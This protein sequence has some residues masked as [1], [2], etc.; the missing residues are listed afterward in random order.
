[1]TLKPARTE[2]YL[3]WTYPRYQPAEEGGLISFVQMS[4]MPFS[5][6]A[7]DPSGYSMIGVQRHPVYDYD[8]PD[9][10]PRPSARI[11][12]DIMNEQ[13]RIIIKGE[14]TTNF[15]HPDSVNQ[16][17]SGTPAYAGPSGLFTHDRDF[18]GDLVGIFLS[19]ISGGSQYVMVQGDIW[20][21]TEIVHNPDGTYVHM[22]L[23][24]PRK[25]V[26]TPGFAKVRLDI[27]GYGKY[28]E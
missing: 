20:K 6:Y 19:E 12:H 5:T 13:I 1:M 21:R 8:R 7:P 17:R 25:W 24:Y 18:S 22:G 14:I 16:I 9:K 28:P 11:T 2:R 26:T 27:Y 23:G 3:S 4:G 10:Q 15:I